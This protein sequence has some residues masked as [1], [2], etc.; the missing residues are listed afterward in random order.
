M[1]FKRLSTMIPM[2]FTSRFTFIKMDT[3]TLAAMKVIGISAAKAPAWE[4]E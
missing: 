2:F 1:E 3:F 4:S